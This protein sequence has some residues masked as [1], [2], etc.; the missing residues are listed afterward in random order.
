MTLR[1][2]A[3]PHATYPAVLLG[4]A[5]WPSVDKSAALDAL[6]ER[7]ST[8]QETIERIRRKAVCFPDFVEVH[9]DYSISLLG[10]ELDW[11]ER[12][13]VKLGDSNEN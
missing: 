2:L 5:N 12:T 13:L 1:F 9:F 3:Q 11:I 4:I 6:Q 7:R 8:I 10:A